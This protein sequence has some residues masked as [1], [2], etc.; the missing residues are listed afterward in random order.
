MKQHP[1]YPKWWP[2]PVEIYSALTRTEVCFD[3]A[4]ELFEARSQNR[5]PLGKAQPSAAGRGAL[6]YH[7]ETRSGRHV[8]LVVFKDEVTDH[9]DR[10]TK[11]KA[12]LKS[13]GAKNF[14]RFSYRPQELLVKRNGH[15]HRFPV[16][17]M[18]WASEPT[19]DLW[20]EENLEHSHRLHQLACRFRSAHFQLGQCGIAHGDLHPWNV[21]VT[22]YSPEILWLD[23][24]PLYVPALETSPPPD[25]GL[26]SFQHPERFR[27]RYWGVNIDAFPARV[28]YT[29]ILVLAHAPALWAKFHVPGEN[30][31]FGSHDFANPGKTE[32]WREVLSIGDQHVQFMLRD[33]L[34]ALNRP[35]SQIPARLPLN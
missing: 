32:L 16:L 23:Y 35:I 31:I 27:T 22:G 29:T 25:L 6:V 3:R 19:L 11:I 5:D 18:D 20:L 33:L 34:G 8:A 10:Y 30:L 2:S 14:L 15:P 12:H 26:D 24:F 9:H 28:I 13:T 4:S 17:I 7:F 21:A 1:K